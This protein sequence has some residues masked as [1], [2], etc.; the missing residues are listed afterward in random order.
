MKL[1]ALCKTKFHYQDKIPPI[2]YAVNIS[3]NMQVMLGKFFPSFGSARFNMLK[4]FSFLG[5]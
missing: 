3:T 5:V 2:Y 1:A 4:L